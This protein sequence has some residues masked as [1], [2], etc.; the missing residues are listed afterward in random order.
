[1]ELQNCPNDCYV[2]ILEQRD[3]APYSGY[4]NGDQIDLEVMIA[5]YEYENRELE[6]EPDPGPVRCAPGSPPVFPGDLI[7]FL[8]LD[9]IYSFAYK[10]DENTLQ[11]L[12]IVHISAWT[13]VELLNK[14]RCQN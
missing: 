11:P 14:Q 12:Q 5:Q 9:G 8:H 1:M 7:F 4:K 6:S 3:P 2:R 13:Q 10:V